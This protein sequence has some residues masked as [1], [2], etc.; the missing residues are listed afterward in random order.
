MMIFHY[1]VDIPIHI[2]TFIS[3]HIPTLQNQHSSGRGIF[4]KH[5][6]RLKLPAAAKQ[7]AAL[8]ALEKVLDNRPSC[9]DLPRSADLLSW[10]WFQE[11]FGEK[12]H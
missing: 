8:E 12:T 7:R 9:Q 10:E 2:P 11:D 3:H 5:R 6:L 4:Q 1:I